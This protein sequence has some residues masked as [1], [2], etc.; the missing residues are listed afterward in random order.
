MEAMTAMS[1][2]QDFT[3]DVRAFL[4]ESRSQCIQVDAGTSEPGQ[5]GFAVAA[6][7]PQ[8]RRE[9]PWSARARRVRSG[10]GI[11]R[12]WCGQRLDVQHVGS[13]RILGPRAG[14]QK[15]LRPGA[16]IVDPLPAR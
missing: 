12:E 16:G 3:N 14:P 11:D 9:S 15:T 13:R 6:V 10:H 7:R 5:H 4:L 1:S 2:F 8:K